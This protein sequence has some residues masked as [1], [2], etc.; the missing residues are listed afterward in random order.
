MLDICNSVKLIVAVLFAERSKDEFA[1]DRHPYSTA[2]T[3]LIT[4]LNLKPRAMSHQTEGILL[5]VPA[6]STILSVP[7]A[8]P[9]PSLPR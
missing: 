1:C 5:L 8:M 3:R 2:E 6:G 7:Y 9:L 4:E